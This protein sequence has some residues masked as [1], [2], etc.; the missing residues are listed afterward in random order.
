MH[1]IWLEFSL[2]L[3]TLMVTE[4]EAEQRYTRG[5]TTMSAPKSVERTT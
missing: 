3:L 2:T 5:S 1:E 4:G